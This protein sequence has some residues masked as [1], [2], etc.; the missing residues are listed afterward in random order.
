ML[1][2]LIRNIVILNTTYKIVHKYIAMKNK[3]DASFSASTF[4]SV[5][6]H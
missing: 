2:H 3:M 4:V 6:E 1:V 5:P